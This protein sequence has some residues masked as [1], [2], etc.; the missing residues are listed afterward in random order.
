[1][2]F[3]T[4][5]KKIET[6]KVRYDSLLITTPSSQTAKPKCPPKSNSQS[7]SPWKPLSS[8]P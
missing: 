5:I 2:D 6:K 1:M 3:L 4:R 8:L 7:P